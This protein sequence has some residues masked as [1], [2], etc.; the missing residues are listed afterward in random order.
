MPGLA[1]FCFL[2]RANL[3]VHRHKREN[4]SFV[5]EGG[6]YLHENIVKA[7]GVGDIEAD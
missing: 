4:F 6:V 2:S 1:F 3:K 5:T 7:G